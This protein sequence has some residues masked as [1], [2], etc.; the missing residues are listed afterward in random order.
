MGK[1]RKSLKQGNEQAVS[2]EL[3][4]GVKLKQA[5]KG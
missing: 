3:Y 4:R 1:L 2:I 5:S